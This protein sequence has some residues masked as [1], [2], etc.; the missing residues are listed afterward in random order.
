MQTTTLR[1]LLLGVV[2]VLALLLPAVPAAAA[3]VAGPAEPAAARFVSFQSPSGNIHCYVSTGRRSG[4]A[5]CDILQKS[6]D[7][8]VTPPRCQGDYG[9]AVGVGKRGRASFLCVFDS[10]VNP[11]SRVLRYGRTVRVGAFRCTS[12]RSGMTCRNVRSGHGFTLARDSY[13][14]R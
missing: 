12:K 14:L 8:P 5:R 1:H 10:A 6:F 9:N 13:R 4:Q 2:A 7:E 3:P 11:D